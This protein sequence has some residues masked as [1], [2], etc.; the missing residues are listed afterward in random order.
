MV[1]NNKQ[2]IRHNTHKEGLEALYDLTHTGAIRLRSYAD[3]SE[4]QQIKLLGDTAFHE[5]LQTPYTN[6]GEVIG[7]HAYVI[8]K[9]GISYSNILNRYDSESYEIDRQAL[10]TDIRQAEDKASAINNRQRKVDLGLKQPF[11]IY[12]PTILEKFKLGLADWGT[13]SQAN[14]AQL[15]YNELLNYKKPLS[16]PEA[17]TNISQL[18][19]HNGYE[20]LV[21]P[22]TITQTLT[23]FKNIIDAKS[24]DPKMPAHLWVQETIQHLSEKIIAYNNFETNSH[25][26]IFDPNYYSFN[27]NRYQTSC[28]KQREI[29]II[30]HY[31][32]TIVKEPTAFDWLKITGTVASHPASHLRNGVEMFRKKSLT[33]T[34]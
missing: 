11:E 20:Y 6:L 16:F 31:A 13:G 34:G 27:E 4:P 22:G 29:A 5:I 17:L 23:P 25:D 12:Y 30:R 10:L 14:T 7:A 33:L 3:N 32:G 21:S 24:A 26:I 19:Y 9:F 1:A 8:G 15:Y 2:P 28:E 18:M